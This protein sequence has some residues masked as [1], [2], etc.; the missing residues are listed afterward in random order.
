[1]PVRGSNASHNDL[2]WPGRP[3]V[4]L[5]V[6]PSDQPDDEIPAVTPGVPKMPALTDPPAAL[7]RVDSAPPCR[8]DLRRRI[9]YGQSPAPRL[10]P[11]EQ[12]IHGDRHPVLPRHTDSLQPPISREAE[13]R[14]ANVQ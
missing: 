2:S 5:L 13:H 12:L 1:M 10:Q 11:R 3:P 8:A 4:P 7:R 9:L 6:D 14:P